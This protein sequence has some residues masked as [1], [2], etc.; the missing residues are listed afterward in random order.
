M[1]TQV[2]VRIFKLSPIHASVIPQFPWIHWIHWNPVRFREHSIDHYSVH[3]YLT[4]LWRNLFKFFIKKSNQIQYTWW[5]SSKEQWL[6]RVWIGSKKQWSIS[7]CIGNEEHCSIRVWINSIVMS[8]FGSCRLK[9]NTAAT[10]R[11]SYM[12][13]VMW[14][15]C[16][17][18]T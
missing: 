13:S 12:L 8:S 11:V 6:I 14:W 7:V 18:C 1:E 5:I 15:S 10:L 9:I 3:F 4:N 17:W 2:T 16:T